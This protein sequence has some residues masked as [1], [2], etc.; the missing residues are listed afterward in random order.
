MAR[1]PSRL[2]CTPKHGG[3]PRE[4]ARRAASS[5][6]AAAREP[7]ALVLDDLDAAD[8]QTQTFVHALLEECQ[9]RADDAG[10]GIA[11]IVATTLSPPAK[12]A[13]T[14]ALSL[15][16][17]AAP[18]AQE[19]FREMCQPLELPPGV[20]RAALERARGVPLYL[21]QLAEALKDTWGRAGSVPDTAELPPVTLEDHA[22]GI[23][24]WQDLSDS[25]RRILEV[26]AVAQRGVRPAEIAHALRTPPSSL[27][28]RLRRLARFEVLVAAGESRSRRYRLASSEAGRALR[29]RIPADDARR[30]HA[31][32]A[33]A[34]RNRRRS[35]LEDTENLAI[36]CLEAR[37]R[38]E[39]R[40]R[41]RR[42]ARELFEQG[43]F[44][45][46]VGLLERA[47]NIETSDRQRAALAEDISDMLTEIGD[48]EKG[49]R[50]LEPFHAAADSIQ[51]ARHT[52]V[53][54]LRRMGVHYHRAGQAAAARTAFEQALHHAD[55]SLDVADLIFIDSELAEM[56]IFGGDYEAAC[57]ACERGLERLRGSG[58]RTPFRQ[59]MEV[60][61]RA[62][63]GH[64]ALRRLELERAREELSKALELGERHATDGD[65]AAILHNLGVAANQ[66]SRF[67]EA[68]G[69]FREAES[70]LLRAGERRNVV[71]ISTNLAVLA[72]KLGDRRDAFFH[73]ERASRLLREYP[74]PRLALFTSYSRGLVL[75]LF[76]DA[77]ESG[78][79]LQKA[80][81]EAEALGDTAIRDFADCYQAE[82]FSV[83]MGR[84]G[85][86]RRLLRAVL[87]RS[88]DALALRRVALSR[89]FALQSLLGKPRAADL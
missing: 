84:Y 14:G 54:L 85:E 35:D 77:E 15:K 87:R 31:R 26:L 88:A 34:L 43:A 42:V 24:D 48:H 40:K 9:R 86:A 58:L 16:P 22:A 11:V 65:R 41:A 79:W 69:C 83:M 75:L 71:K 72:S 50:I 44:D 59:R 30:I 89:L 66:S 5:F 70:L 13:H 78:S 19:V 57:E 82:V 37:R 3:S 53:R 52:R 62:S 36:A 56:H 8:G 67:E 63:L 61:L 49:V 33:D 25:E 55:P 17:L 51:I 47:L 20:I 4:R 10:G 28:R 76:G 32:L 7:A 38:V 39:G 64:V 27:S 1:T 60:M 29:E 2:P 81:A 12:L 68:R 6:F 21:H 73:L 74:G 23:L 45:R 46:A 80:A 18:D